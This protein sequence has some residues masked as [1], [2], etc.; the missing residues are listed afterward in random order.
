MIFKRLAGLERRPHGRHDDPE[1]AVVRAGKQDAGG[2]SLPSI[3]ASSASGRS[4]APGR[5]CCSQLA[6]VPSSPVLLTVGRRASK[7]A[8]GPGHLGPDRQGL[9]GQ[10]G[11]PRRLVLR[12]LGLL[13]GLVVDGP[14]TV[15]AGDLAHVAEA[16]QPVVEALFV[17][18]AHD[19]GPEGGQVVDER[20]G[21]LD[22][23]P[24]PGIGLDVAGSADPGDGDGMP[25][26]DAGEDRG[27]LGGRLGAE[28][29][30]APVLVKIERRA[31]GAAVSGQSAS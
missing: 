26:V 3:L 29:G 16:R 31:G 2:S 10:D 1:R 25:A 7:I 18:G 14:E 13:D 21:R 28:L 8:Q 17:T 22:L 27:G 4:Q 9:L 12:R 15:E 19:F 30:P 6:I 5:R 24:R 23:V 11:Q 20:V